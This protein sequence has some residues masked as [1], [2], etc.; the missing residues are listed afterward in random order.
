M[1]EV[2]TNKLRKAMIDAGIDTI[3][4]L[5]EKA[6][7]NRVTAG[8]VVKGRIYPSSMV[9]EKI[10]IALGLTSEDAGLIFFKEKLA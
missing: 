4:Q 6:G 3:E 8:D 9:M 10:K 7:I 2:D 1:H 5:A